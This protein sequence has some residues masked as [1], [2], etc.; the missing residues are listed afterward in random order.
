MIFN[1]A[2]P[3]SY[4]SR[5]MTLMAGDVVITGSP[6][7]VGMGKKPKPICLKSGDVV[8]LGIEKLG[9][10]RQIVHAWRDAR[11]EIE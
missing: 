5:L 3:V 8:T 2:Y 1:C 6:P 9:Q 11:K 10:Q 4:V 7:G